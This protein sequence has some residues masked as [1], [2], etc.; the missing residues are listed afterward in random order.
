[1][2][3]RPPSFVARLIDGHGVKF[4]RYSGVS[5]V[6]VIIGQ[7]MLYFFHAGVGL[8]GWLANVAAVTISTA[9]AYW[10]MR[11]WVWAQSGA[12][13]FTNEV[14]PFW[15]MAFVGLVL[16][17]VVVGIV[18][19]KGGSEVAVQFASIGSFG[20]L[21]VF[22]YVLLEKVMWRDATGHRHLLHHDEAP[23]EA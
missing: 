4:F 16:S 9:P 10:M 11:H 21:W 15:G 2:P 22:K 18:D 5:V 23:V 20:L 13:S 19:H 12:H 8:P 6:N 3:E 14:A 17:T 1:M 7:S